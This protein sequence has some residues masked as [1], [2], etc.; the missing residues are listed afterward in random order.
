MPPWGFHIKPN[1]K[2]KPKRG[3]MEVPH[4]PNG[5]V[6]KD[7]CI[8]F[9]PDVYMYKRM[10]ISHVARVIPRDRLRQSNNCNYL[11]GNL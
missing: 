3:G 1:M 7:H 10:C 6:N 8:D 9:I 4:F 11:K 5:S 2:L